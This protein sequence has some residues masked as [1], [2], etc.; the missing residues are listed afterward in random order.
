MLRRH[1]RWMPERV[2][3]HQDRALAELREWAIRRSGF[4]PRFHPGRA[5]RAAD[6]TRA[7]ADQAW[8][9]RPFTVYGA[10]ETSGIAA[11]CERRPG[12][13]LF[14]DL[15]ITEVVDEQYRPVPAGSSGKGAGHRCCSRARCR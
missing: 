5:D 4:F 9:A 6:A 2:G 10:T 14:E 13:H 3:A 15:V 1:D 8:T 11:E 12:M 7:L